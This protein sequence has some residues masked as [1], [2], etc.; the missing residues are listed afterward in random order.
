MEKNKVGKENKEC[1][2]RVESAGVILNRMIMEGLSEKV[3]FDP[4]SE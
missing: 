4:R 2:V 1:K 3:T